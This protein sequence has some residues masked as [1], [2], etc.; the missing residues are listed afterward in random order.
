MLRRTEQQQQ[1]EQQYQ[2]QQQQQQQ[3]QQQQQQEGLKLPLAIRPL[4]VKAAVAARRQHLSPLYPWLYKKTRF[5]RCICG[6]QLGVS[7]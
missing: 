5:M 2:Q 3:E 4:V 6:T 7:S 1:Q